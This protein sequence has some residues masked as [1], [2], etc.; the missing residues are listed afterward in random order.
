MVAVQHLCD[1]MLHQMQ[2]RL[3]ETSNSSFLWRVYGSA[4]SWMKLR[5]VLLDDLINRSTLKCR[6]RPPP[7]SKNKFFWFFSLASLS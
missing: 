7:P 1:T 4:T 5:I 2:P 3:L 6:I